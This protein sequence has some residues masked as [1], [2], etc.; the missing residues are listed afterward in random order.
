M[1]VIDPHG[2]GATEREDAEAL[3]TQARQRQHRRWWVVGTLLV[4]VILAVGLLL[5]MKGSGG[6]TGPPAAQQPPVNFAGG[7]S[8]DHGAL[9]LVGFHGLQIAVPAKWRL[10]DQRCGAAEADTVLYPDL[11]TDLCYTISPPNITVVTFFELN[12]A[13]RLG[14]GKAAFHTVADHGHMVS[15][16]WLAPTRLWPRRLLVLFARQMGAAVAVLSPSQTMA[17]HLVASVRIVKVD[18]TG[19]PS[20]QLVLHPTGPSALPGGAKELVPGSPTRVALCRY[21][22]FWL[23]ESAHATGHALLRLVTILNSLKAGTSHLPSDFHEPPSL[24]TQDAERAFLLRFSYS[25]GSVEPVFVH[26]SGCG[27]LSAT[28]ESRGGQ[29]DSAIETALVQ[30]LGYGVGPSPNALV[31]V[32]PSK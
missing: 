6:R 1:K 2:L 32:P 14:W 9:S 23:A 3:I 18:A 5:A 7:T 17:Q 11:V 4:A 13:I 28:N 27:V 20:E 22:D 19:C 26:I 8:T 10:E 31:G 29:I 24:C 15:V 21:E 16:G 30:V 12:T 25:N